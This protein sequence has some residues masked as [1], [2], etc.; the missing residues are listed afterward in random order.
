MAD[1]QDELESENQVDGGETVDNE[2]TEKEPDY[3]QIAEDQRKRAE[4][5]EAKLKVKPKVEAPTQP[6]NPDALTR[7]EAI[8]IAEGMKVEDLEELQVVA[9]AKNLSLLKA[10]DTP[11]FQAYLEKQEAERKK[12]KAKI[13]AS[14]GSQEKQE[15]N[16]SELTR[17]EHEALVRET[18][19][20]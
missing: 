13:S 7:E 10:K 11:L 3:K 16:V 5:A 8:L 17:S 12:E 1:E 6:T 9:K 2:T 20:N 4:I 19:G 14:K 18:F 15:R